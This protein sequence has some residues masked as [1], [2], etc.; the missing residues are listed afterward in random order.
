MNTEQIKSEYHA[1][2][3]D[4]YRAINVALNFSHETGFRHQELEAAFGEDVAD[5]LSTRGDKG[6]RGIDDA[7]DQFKAMLKLIE[8]A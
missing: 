5:M 8:G 6:H 7:R 4:A 2:V 1:A 3:S